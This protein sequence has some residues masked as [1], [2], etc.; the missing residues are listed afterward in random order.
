MGLML[1]ISGLAFAAQGYVTLS[2][3]QDQIDAAFE[4]NTLRPQY[5]AAANSHMDTVPTPILAVFGEKKA[6]LYVTLDSGIVQTY[7]VH[8]EKN[9]LVE[10]SRGARSEA[11]L[12]V[13]ASEQTIDRVLNADEPGSEFVKAYNSGEIKYKGLDSDS[14]AQGVVFDI[15][16]SVAGF[17]ERIFSIFR[18]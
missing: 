9:A 1:I 18:D 4:N 13:R 5:I 16:A 7:W 14:K 12:E 3:N 15:F 11:N 6:N 8:M 17:I 10:I 2:Q